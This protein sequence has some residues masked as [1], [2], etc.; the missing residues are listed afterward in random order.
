MSAASSRRGGPVLFL[1]AAN[2]VCTA[3]AAAQEVQVTPWRLDYTP[4]HD[5][6]KNCPDKSYIRTA[7]ATK[8][9]GRDPF[10]DDA[11]RSISVKLVPTP[12]RI[13]AHIEARD[14]NGNVVA[15]HIT[16]ADSWRCDRLADRTVFYLRDIVDPIALPLADAAPVN[17]S[18][19]PVPSPVPS[20]PSPSRPQDRTPSSPACR[21]P[22]CSPL[23]P[24]LALS[25]SAGAT[26]WSAP[27]T[28]MSLALGTEARWPRFSVGI[29]GHYDHVWDLPTRQDVAA[30]QAGLVALV[31]ARRGFFSDRAFARACFFG[32]VAVL[33]IGSDKAELEDPFADNELVLDLGARLGGEFW[34]AR[35]LGLE[36]HGDVAYVPRRPVFMVD[37]EQIWSAPRFTG[38]LRVG[39]VLPF[40]IR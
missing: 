9:K 12:Q 35:Y 8:L 24:K 10:T 37:G 14:E 34:L 15:T 38:A 18:A 17:S 29:E 19:P 36:L 16:H 26:W 39:L 40:D 27:E 33:S 22:S 32:R 21:V 30:S 5:A 2:L 13:E 20:P 11:P 7:V 31:C 23:I 4:G 3:R 1:V 25:A 28:A 6:P